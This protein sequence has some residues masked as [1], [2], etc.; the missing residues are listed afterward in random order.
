MHQISLLT[1]AER[2]ELVARNETAVGVPDGSVAGLFAARA[3][4]V[5]DAV[6]VTDGDAVVSYR[7]LA[8]AAARVASRLAQVG[9]GP[10]SVVAVMVPR[11]VGMVTAV[12]GV[13]WAGA[14]Y[15]PL[16][17]GYPLG[18]IAFMLADARAVAA[19]C[20]WQ[21]ADALPAGPVGPQQV[22]LDDP[23]T[24]IAAVPAGGPV[25]VRPGG[26]AYV[27]YTSG[28]TGTPKGVVATQG[29]VAG[30]ACDR[31]WR[32]GHERVLVHSAQV[33][34]AVTY[35]L[36][37]PLLGGGTAVLAPAGELDVAGLAAVVRGES[38]SAVF[39]TTALFNLVAAEAPES[40]AAVAQVWTGGEKES[41]PAM[42]R[43]L[44]QCPGTSVVHVYGPT[45]ATTFATCYR[46]PGG[47]P[48][49]GAVPIGRPMDNTQVS[50]LDGGLGLVPDGVTGEL[51]V[52][53]EG[54]ARGYLGQPAL[55]A[56]RFV[57]C[58]F[59]PAGGRMY[60][61][62]DLVRWQD[63]QLVFA[64]RAD[65]QVKV[66]G[67][68][69]EPGEITAVLAGHPGVGQAV[70]IVREDTPGRKQL[71]GY[72][73]P[74]AGA[75]GADDGEG[76]REFVAG[77]LP[78]F[79]V[80]AAVVV[81]D[82]LPVTV[83]GKLDTAALPAPGF[84]GAG[85][86]GPAT[87]TEEVLCG[88]F[89]E[90]LGLERVGAQDGFFDLG[91]DSLLGMRLVARVRAVLGAD[92]EV[93]E[94]FAAPSPAGLAVAVEA[95][96]GQ[97]AR[98]RLVPV[99]R[100]AVVPLSF[101]QLRLWFLAGLEDTGAAYHIPV[102]V[103]VAGPVNAAA[104]EAA[105]GDVAARHE[106]LRTVFP[107]AGGVPRQQ[108]LD[109]A[110]GAPGLTVREVEDGQVAGA[111]AAAAVAPFD[112]AAEV[113][114]RAQLLVTG[115]EQAVLVVVVHHIATDGWSMQV[116]GQDL[117]VAYAARA[118]G[119]EPAWAALP[120]QYADYAIWQRQLLGDASD[121]G[122]VM[123]AQL[124][125][126]R[127]QLAGL[128]GGLELPA[129][130]V[131]PPVVSYAGGRV[132][133]RVPASVRAGLA[134]LARAQDAT[135]FM[136][137]LAATGL[138]LARLGAGDDI[139]VGT[140]VAGR[141]DEAMS[142]L[143]GFFVNT[144]V[145]R[146]RVAAA[147][148]FTA[149]LAGAREA[150]LGAY[151]HQDVPFEHLVDDLR[152]ERSLSRHPLFQ[153]MLAFQNNPRPHLDLPGAAIS[154]L[155]A[156]TGATK[157]DLQFSWWETPGQ[158][159]SGGLDGA[160]V[161][162]TDLFS[163]GAAGLVAGR[164]VRVLEQVAADPG[165]RV[166]Q[167]SLLSDGERAELAARNRTGALVPDDTVAGL[168]ADRA[169][170]VPDAVAVTDGDAVV[171][172]RFLAAAAARLGARLAGVG[173]G[174][175]SVVA[176]MVPRSVGM[177]TAVLG[178]LW[179]GAAYL[180][181]DAGYP[182]ER[183]SFMLTNAG[184]V[185]LVCTAA[186]GQSAGPASL[187]R[188]LLDAPGTAAAAAA[189]R[190]SS[191]P[192]RVRPGG[193]AYVMYTSGSTGTPKGV[194]VTHGGVAGLV[195]WAAGRF[196]PGGEFSRVLGSTSLSFD[197]SVFE[198]LGPL[199]AGGCVYLVRDLLALAD[200]A[201]RAATVSLVS[202][203]PSALT[204]VLAATGALAGPA[205]VVLAGE[206]LTAAT[207]GAVR[208]AVPGA[209]LANIYGPTEATVYAAAWFDDG[210]QRGPGWVPPIGRPI[211]NTRVFVLD[212]GL[213]L[214]PDG[215]MGELYVAGAGLARGYLGQPGLTAGRFVACPFGPA[216]A[217][218][219]R[220]G[221]LVRWQ[222][223]QLV[224]AGRADEQVKVRGFRVEPGEVAAV[225]AGCPGVGQV[226]VIAREDV[227]GQK[228]LVA[229]VV[230]AGD[231]PVDVAG[232]REYVAGR[233]PEY[234]VPAAIVVLDALPVTVNGKLDRA[235]LPVPE[236]SGA[237]GRGRRRL[238]RRCCAA[239]SRRC[240]AWIR[241]GRRTGFLIWAGTASCRCSWWRGRGRRGWC[242]ARAMC[243]RPGPRPGWPPSPKRR[244]WRGRCPLM[245]APAR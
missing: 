54:L 91:G 225:L 191:S 49:A 218:M 81:L 3:V 181:L 60:R 42:G 221:D 127:A 220:T 161:Y 182:P 136:V 141:P 19:V 33:F 66:R 219:Y 2:A 106:S 20:T 87:A 107:A 137:A 241:W 212:G 59:G 175:E 97:P 214:V 115:P 93:G 128:P 199:C 130:R 12:L 120:V 207:L 143:V 172:Y 82:A 22:I 188:V 118:A 117:S 133:W 208:A 216:G 53:G 83:N 92:I 108:V 238:R 139:P 105:L 144:L 134:E 112:L 228:R 99:V 151:A 126:W 197:V 58:P 44:A 157:F 146:T 171:S 1:D 70:V 72:V 14:A 170:R 116:L 98:P 68:R 178:V 13:L 174:P 39:V 226:V 222:G 7:F 25:R 80:P 84:T 36:W 129:D 190:G 85:G 187:P 119:R 45:E 26:A 110:A 69:V 185:A 194:V 204:Q 75:V 18:R 114:W 168:F 121:E 236:F 5:P 162:R 6:A 210:G 102:A 142:G 132:G 90:V 34:D 40:L 169:R 245:W 183:I 16:D 96:W 103:R 235:A 227:P 145:L 201:G 86:R 67:F 242:S 177:V 186:V 184:A 15:L 41:G 164:L 179:A 234:M 231:G 125:Y 156:S 192:V 4:R 140:P 11:S 35:E 27:M 57:A 10:E 111:V 196:G 56:G 237:G 203:V 232:L 155:P 63:G 173:A 122:S 109:P 138:L 131:R 223:G 23:G 202:A 32:G 244:G 124:G 135:M 176:V 37:V 101:A 158:S 149:L 159:G 21:S 77:R 79:M 166:Y 148:S 229:Y 167:V 74:A 189:G 213:G 8:A 123:A 195:A 31:R 153:V 152:P 76:L 30:L 95:V 200:Q 217:R 224:F 71:T 46:V 230:P 52:M 29:G 198:L 47:G 211:A 78:E 24:A 209:S 88:L 48:G 193:V 233:L 154:Q 215:V 104:L 165:L 38:V 147:D 205:M 64:G 206:A 65:G 89:A 43:V 150:A 113:P 28:S 9:V 240:W 62:G 163:A 50:V 51:Y 160:V 73:V 61:T 100:P 243:S 180:P 55:T 17:P 94:L 239:C